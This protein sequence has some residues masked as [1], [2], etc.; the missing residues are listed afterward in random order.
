QRRRARG[1]DDL[2]V[3]I[4]HERLARDFLTAE[5]KDLGIE[6][7]EYHAEVLRRSERDRIVERRAGRGVVDLDSLSLSVVGD[8]QVDRRL[9]VEEA[10]AIR[11]VRSRVAEVVGAREI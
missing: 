1:A 7:A 11:V 9:R 6:P 8:D 5:R 2:H 3:E 4:V 10:E